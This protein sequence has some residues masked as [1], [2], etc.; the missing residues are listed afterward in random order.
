MGLRT[1]HE[2]C[3]RRRPAS[4]FALAK[5]V[6]ATNG[7]SDYEAVIATSRRKGSRRTIARRFG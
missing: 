7:D 5:I 1:D 2:R 4:L 6:F 3:C